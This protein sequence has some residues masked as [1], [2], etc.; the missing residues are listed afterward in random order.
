MSAARYRLPS[1]VRVR[2]VPPPGA[3]ASPLDR[4]TWLTPYEA[5]TIGEDARRA[6]PGA[7]LE[8]LIPGPASTTRLEAVKTLF[9]WL[10]AK[11]IDVSVR[12]DGRE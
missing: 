2:L 12:V 3:R 4:V 10:G 9:A 7:R 8:V 6:G 11:G 5:E 1:L